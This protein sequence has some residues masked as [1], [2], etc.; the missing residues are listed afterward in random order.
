MKNNATIYSRSSSNEK[1]PSSCHPS[2]E[3]WDV[4]EGL[5]SLTLIHEKYLAMKKVLV[6]T[7]I[8]GLELVSTTFLDEAS[9]LL[10]SLTGKQK[11][12]AQSTTCCSNEDSAGAGMIK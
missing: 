11:Q 12:T 2:E 6:K 8:P 7:K 5:T 3:L 4:K 10:S 1:K 9:D